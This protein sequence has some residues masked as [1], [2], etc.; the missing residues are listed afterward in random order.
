MAKIS[1]IL[2][3]YNQDEFFEEAITS[4][5]T[6]SY[7]DFELIISENGSTDNSK[8][9]LKKYMYHKKIKI[10]NYVENESVSKRF[11]QALNECEGEFVSF[12]YSDDIISKDK[13]KIQ[14]QEFEKLDSD[15]GVVYGNM[16][17]FNQYTNKSFTRSVVKSDG[18]C[19]KQQLDDIILKGHV[20]MVSPLSRKECFNNYQFLENVFAEG[21]G[22]FLRIALSYKFKYLSHTFAYFR[23]TRFN[24]GKALIKNLSFHLET[25]KKLQQDKIFEKKEYLTAINK[26]KF[27]FQQNIAWG[28]LRANGVTKNS[29][30]IFIDILKLKNL[31][32][33]N[34][35]TLCILILLCFPNFILKIF[36]IMLNKILNVKTNNISIENYGGN[37]K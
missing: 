18:W 37:N 27:N 7:Q 26:Y 6:Q 16:K 5:L 28:N 17:I 9:I 1:V 30:K 13:F 32:F 2:N 14:I 3:S 33:F 15:Y 20:D 22:I 23:D 21:E 29:K 10:L 11:N 25:L 19:L 12:L 31:N 24:N 36:N 4:V 8:Q 34:F 35:Q